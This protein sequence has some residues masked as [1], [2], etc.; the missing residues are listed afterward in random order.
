MDTHQLSGSACARAQEGPER[1]WLGLGRRG[2]AESRGLRFVPVRGS[3]S[4][5]RLKAPSYCCHGGARGRHVEMWTLLDLDGCCGGHDTQTHSPVD[6]SQI[7][8]GISSQSDKNVILG[9][10]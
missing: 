4:R 10:S 8:L 5:E 6:V 7:F 3:F 2:A 1:R 9:S